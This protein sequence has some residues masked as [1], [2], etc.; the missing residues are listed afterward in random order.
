MTN[1]HTERK[2]DKY[3]P[4]V[5]EY[6]FLFKIMLI[7]DT[8]VGKSSILLRYVDDEFRINYSTTIGVDFK[9]KTVDFA[10]KKIKTQI[11]D[12]AGQERFRSIINS[13]YRGV[14]GAFIVFDLTDLDSF[15]N[16][17]GWVNDLNKYSNKQVV[18]ILIGNKNDLVNERVI[19]RQTAESY[20]SRSGMLYIETSAKTSKNINSCFQNL[21]KNIH[22]N[23]I[24]KE[25]V[26]DEYKPVKLQ[27]KNSDIIHDDNCC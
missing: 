22:R 13:Y 25:L 15:N 6:D 7:G 9:I 8:G 11:W 19:S 24:A 12:T 18:R 23:I 4:F 1:N 16:V 2:D 5:M 3:S 21:I 14:H 10:D 26:I 20:A 27:M 17:D